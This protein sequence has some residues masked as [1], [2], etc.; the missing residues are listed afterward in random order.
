MA[1]WTAFRHTNQLLLQ[2]SA[3]A[4]DL[5]LGCGNL[6]GCALALPGAGVNRFLG[7]L[8]ARRS[9]LLIGRWGG[10]AAVGRLTRLPGAAG[11]W[12]AVR[13]EG[14]LAT[15]YAAGVVVDADGIALRP[16]AGGVVGGIARFG[17]AA[18]GSGPVNVLPDVVQVAHRPAKGHIHGLVVDVD[19]FAVGS[20]APIGG[21]VGLARLVSQGRCAE[22]RVERIFADFF[23]P[24]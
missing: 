20:A 14:D 8:T 5:A 13:G 23:N 24:C 19:P 9:I 4:G 2:W 18:L 11:G 3:G 6:A 12:I 16:V 15:A 22:E 1:G 7:R 21:I 10:L 17:V